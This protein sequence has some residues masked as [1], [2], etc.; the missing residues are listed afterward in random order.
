MC[1]L[2]TNCTERNSGGCQPLMSSWNHKLLITPVLNCCI[3]P[4]GGCLSVRRAVLPYSIPT[5]CVQPETSLPQLPRAD[6][7][8][9]EG[10]LP[11][12]G[13]ALPDAMTP[14][15]LIPR[16]PACIPWGHQ[17]DVYGPKAVCSAATRCH[18]DPGMSS[19]PKCPRPWGTSGT[20]GVA[21]LHPRSSSI[22]CRTHSW[23]SPVQGAGSRQ[24]QERGRCTQRCYETTPPH[25]CIWV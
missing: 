16:R 8:K 2:A 22:I 12:Q 23:G 5:Y 1:Y 7:P 4:T 18:R 17:A 10:P 24:M 13:Q 21:H 11:P 25:A 3:A 19:T 6:G 15:L 14:M 20:R 9:S